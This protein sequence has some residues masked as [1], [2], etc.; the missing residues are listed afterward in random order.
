M[1]KTLYWYITRELLSVVFL[2]T[3]A[4]T[5]IFSMVV[6]VEP[7][8]EH[9]LDMMKAALFFCYSLPMVL[10]LTLPVAS[11]FAVTFVYGRLTQEREFIACRASGVSEAKLMLPAVLL[12]LIVTVATIY[13]TNYASPRMVRKGHAMLIKQVQ[14]IVFHKLESEGHFKMPNGWV[15]HASRVDKAKRNLYGV[16]ISR[17]VKTKDETGKTVRAAEHWLVPS[18]GLKEMQPG[19]DFLAFNVVDPAGPYSHSVSKTTSGNAKKFP[20]RRAELPFKKA[21]D[22]K[23]YDSWELLKLL[24]K[25]TEY[26]KIRRRMEEIRENIRKDRFLTKATTMLKDSRNFPYPLTGRADVSLKLVTPVAIKRGDSVEMKSRGGVRVR[27]VRQGVG[28]RSVF[29][30]DTGTIQVAQK[31][32]S[33]K[34]YVVLT[35][36]GNVEETWD[37]NDS[38]GWSEKSFECKFSNDKII[39][40]A[41]YK[42]LYD[43]I[44]RYTSN[45]FYQD[46]FVQTVKEHDE[47]KLYRE[48][49]AQLYFRNIYGVIGIVLIA[50]GALLSIIRSSSGHFLLGAFAFTIFPLAGTLLLMKMGQRLITNSDTV[51]VSIPGVC[52]MW[53]GIAAISIA[54]VVLFYKLSRR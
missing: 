10:S 34:Y 51:G 20:I 1:L 14:D 9:G 41:T 40:N 23:E 35:L 49:V 54:N 21:G 43:N 18:V 27:M 50:F 5:I 12:G 22:I 3:F 33:N 36:K 47:P 2:A 8:R 32:M 28:S 7:L 48:V 24:E 19:D 11:L 53:S 39:E 46:S 26:P 4:F 15:L 17:S 42:D 29:E 31:V 44:G 45:K 16:A 25:P 52:I 30:A 37:R 13:M 6:V 38:R